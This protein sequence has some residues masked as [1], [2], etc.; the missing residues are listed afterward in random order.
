MVAKPPSAPAREVN[1]PATLSLPAVDAAPVRSLIGRIRHQLR[2]A[3]VAEIVDRQDLQVSKRRAEE[4][5]H[6]A[7]GEKI[8][9]TERPSC[10]FPEGTDGVLLQSPGKE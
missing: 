2:P 1:L 5:V 7:S 4:L 10:P 6:L 8:L 3:T 9:L